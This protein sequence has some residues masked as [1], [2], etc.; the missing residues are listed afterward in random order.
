MYDT[1]YSG[2][3][4]RCKKNPNLLLC[5]VLVWQADNREFMGA[6]GSKPKHPNTHP[7][8]VLLSLC[9]W[10]LALT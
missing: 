2:D 3:G 4:C 6:H 5:S 1:A 7:K 9:T 10:A 8:Y